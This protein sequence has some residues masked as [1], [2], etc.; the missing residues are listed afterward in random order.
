MIVKRRSRL[1]VLLLRVID[2]RKPMKLQSIV[3]KC[4][5]GE[6]LWRWREVA[7]SGVRRAVLYRE[8]RDV[9]GYTVLG[10]EAGN[11]RRRR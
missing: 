7:E 2:A 4:A 11:G 5:P 10:K 8:R 6:P 1:A 3:D 9:Y